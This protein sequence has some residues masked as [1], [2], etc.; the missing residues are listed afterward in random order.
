MKLLKN[1]GFSDYVIS[2]I[3]F[4]MEYDDVFKPIMID[5]YTTKYIIDRLGN[6]Y[7]SKNG[8][9]LVPQLST[10]GYYRVKLSHNKISKS[11]SVHRLVAYAFIPNPLNKPDVN[12][13]DGVKS[14]NYV[15]NLEWVTKS[16]NS[17]HAYR[18]GLNSNVGEINPK[19]KLTEND[20]IAIWNDINMKNESFTNIGKKYG[21]SKATISHIYKGDTWK[22]LYD[23]YHID[24]DNNGRQFKYS[25]DI[26]KK[27]RNY[28]SENKLN[29]KEI[30]KITEINL[31][32]LY[33]LKL[34]YYRK[35]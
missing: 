34:N 10:G 35:E 23:I 18:T 26:I 31:N 6:V 21:V 29:M 27:A 12:H 15:E 22:E 20:V 13:I 32:Y 19:A 24:D 8:K 2:N 17:L 33:A 7:N 16:E 25:D 3:V 30:S 5:G 4:I 28:L 9:T 1:K 14:H 11:Y